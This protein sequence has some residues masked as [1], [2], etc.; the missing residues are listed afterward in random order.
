M[1]NNNDISLNKPEEIDPLPETLQEGART[2]L[3]SAIEAQIEHFL[4]QPH[5]GILGKQSLFAM[6]TF[7]SG[8]YKQVLAISLSRFQKREIAQAQD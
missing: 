5:L 2:L 7:L 8:Q 1:S 3:V 4:A 6:V